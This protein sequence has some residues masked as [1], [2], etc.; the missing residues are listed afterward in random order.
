[1]V[2]SEGV[3]QATA[4]PL[5][6]Y[7]WYFIFF[8]QGKVLNC[9]G[10]KSPLVRSASPIARGNL[11]GPMKDLLLAGN[12]SKSSLSFCEQTGPLKFRCSLLLPLSGLFRKK[13]A[14]RGLLLL[15]ILFNSSSENFTS[16]LVRAKSDCSCQMKRPAL[17]NS[18]LWFWGSMYL[19]PLFLHFIPFAI[20]YDLG[21]C[22]WNRL[23]CVA[24]C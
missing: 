14:P 8:V 9:D 15:V 7:K 11:L 13:I 6:E 16:G 12:C 2:V 3:E 4:P 10:G 19:L 17:S 22:V 5:P 23:L 24:R 18:N 20:N 21:C 1:M